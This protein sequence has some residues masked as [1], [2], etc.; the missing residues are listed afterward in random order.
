MENCNGQKKVFTALAQ[1]T[2]AKDNPEEVTALHGKVY[3]W[4][5]EFCEH[6]PSDAFCDSITMQIKLLKDTNL[7]AVEDVKKFGQESDLTPRHSVLQ[8]GSKC[9]LFYDSGKGKLDFDMIYLAPSSLNHGMVG[10]FAACEFLAKTPIGV[11]VG[12]QLC[13]EPHC[14]VAN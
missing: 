6:M 8:P 9:S 12:L 5:Y 11:Y 2:L 3:Q 4:K 13:G 7:N 14:L 10:V 1:V